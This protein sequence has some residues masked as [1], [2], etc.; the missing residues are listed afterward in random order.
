MNEVSHIVD[1]T[2]LPQGSH[3]GPLL[4]ILF[5]NDLTQVIFNSYFYVRLFRL[6]PSFRPSI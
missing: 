5:L 4:F 2:Y 3:L 1:V 6:V